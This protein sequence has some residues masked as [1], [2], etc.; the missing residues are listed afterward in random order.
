M[1]A[2]RAAGMQ[3]AGAACWVRRTPPQPPDVVFHEAPSP[4]PKSTTA[5]AGARHR[6]GGRSEGSCDS[7]R[8]QPSNASQPELCRLRRSAQPLHPWP[9]KMGLLPAAQPSP[10]LCASSPHPTPFLPVYTSPPL[11]L[12]LAAIP[13]GSVVNNSTSPAQG[14]SQAGARSM[15]ARPEVRPWT[16]AGIGGAAPPTGLS[17]TPLTGRMCLALPAGPAPAGTQAHRVCTVRPN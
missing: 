2:G 4:G 13:G 16:Q 6:I 10:P 15:R 8:H 12:P 14:A 5:G 1:P 3:R 11:M 9:R 7:L 17:L